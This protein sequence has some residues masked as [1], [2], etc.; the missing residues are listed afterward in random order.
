MKSERRFA[1]VF[2]TAPSL[3]AARSLARLALEARVIACANLIPKIESHY[4]WESKIET[5]KEVLMVLKTSN[6]RLTE[7]QKLILAKHPYETPEFVV[8]QV[9]HANKCYLDWL[10]SS[11][12]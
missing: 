5:A 9:D 1:F 6:H 7:L 3:K 8:M 2:V 12:Q 11:V 4:W 10:A